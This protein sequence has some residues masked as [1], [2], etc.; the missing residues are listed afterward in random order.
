LP[1]TTAGWELYDLDADPRETN[2]V[3]TDPTYRLVIK[4][5]KSRLLELKNEFGDHDEKYPEL[6]QLRGSL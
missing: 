6:M 1:Q 2:N 4:R 5:L 3:Y